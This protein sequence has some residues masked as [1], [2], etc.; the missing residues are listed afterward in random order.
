MTAATCDLLA[1]TLHTI[2]LNTDE[3]VVVGTQIKR[4]FKELIPMVDNIIENSARKSTK[5]EF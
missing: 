3:C 4:L 2:C 1:T 5:V